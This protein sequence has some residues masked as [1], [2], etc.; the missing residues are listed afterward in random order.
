MC[1][2]DRCCVKSY[3]ES[4]IRS[5]IQQEMNLHRR[6]C[7]HQVEKG[8]VDLIC[9][10]TGCQCQVEPDHSYRALASEIFWQQRYSRAGDEGS[11]EPRFDQKRALAHRIGSDIRG[12]SNALPWMGEHASELVNRNLVGHDGKTGLRIQGIGAIHERVPAAKAYGSWHVFVS[13]GVFVGH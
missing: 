5:V 12:L 3:H 8:F 13:E 2:K 11:L 4:P 6:Q 1:T 7:L 10:S 9:A